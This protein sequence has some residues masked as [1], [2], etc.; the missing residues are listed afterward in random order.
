MSTVAVEQLVEQDFGA[1]PG[2]D[3][4]R[5][6]SAATRQLAARY[7]SGQIGRTLEPAGFAIDPDFFLLLPSLNRIYAEAVTLIARHAP[8][9]LE[10]GELL[11]GA[12]TLREAMWHRVPLLRNSYLGKNVPDDDHITFRKAAQPEALLSSVSHTTLGF[13]KLLRVG[14]RGLREE[15]EARL[16]RGGLDETGVDLLDSMLT[17]LAA[18]RTWHERYVAEVRNRL[19]GATGAKAKHWQEVLC[20]LEPVPE[21]PPE[22]FRQALQALW[23][24]WDFQRLCGNWS[25]LGRVD[26]MLGGFLRRDLATGALT[27]DQARELIAHFWIKGCEWITAEGRG[28]GDAQFYQ[29]VILAGVDEDGNEVANEVTDLVLDVVEEL[30]ISDFPIAVRLNRRTPDRLLRR[31]AQLQRRGGGIVAIYNEE[32]IIPTLE[33]FGYPPRQARGFTNDGCWELLI[34]GQTCF[35]YQPFD[36]LLLLQETLGL[37]AKNAEQVDY[38]DFETLYAEFRRRLAFQLTSLVNSS[39]RS[40]HPAPLVSLLVEGCVEKG[41]GYYD[42]GPNYTVLS[43]HPGG[44]PDVANSLLAIRSL[45]FERQELTLPELTETLRQD[46]ADREALRRRWRLQGEFYGNDQTAADAMMKRL[47]DD[48]TSLVAQVHQRLGILRPAGISTFGRESST[49]LSSRLATAAGSRRG[50]LLAPNF[51][52]A[53]GTDR[54]GPTAVIKS[55]CAMDFSR[56]PCGTALDLKLLP[57][58]VAGETGLQAMVGLLKTFVALGGIFLQLDVVDS[59]LLRDAQ[60]QPE[61]Y[62]NLAVRISG[63]SARFATLTPE[64]QELVIQRSEQRL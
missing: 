30:H 27:L 22:N 35:S 50:E 14:Y 16:A 20:A 28:S 40:Y 12:A 15:I 62:P 43:P 8:L 37:G 34:P 31:V 29:N 49:Y 44:L 53:P 19:T 7:L 58:S 59:Q 60:A 11:V 2:S 32:R 54:L 63:W 55:H 41:R 13:A 52:P 56:L 57:A 45:V 1:T 47:F 36:T 24:A 46:W 5:R 64:W 48:F 9:R 10:A 26:Q 33:K 4:P 6:L 39:N 18:A 17:C 25:G 42:L 23:L 51:S 21:S 3:S 61:K 38:P